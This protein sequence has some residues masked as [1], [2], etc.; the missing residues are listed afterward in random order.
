M[1]SLSFHL[2]KPS[3]PWS[4]QFLSSIHHTST[5][6]QISGSIDTFVL[7]VEGMIC[8]WVS[9]R[10]VSNQRSVEIESVCFGFRHA[11]K[12][13]VLASLWN[14]YNGLCLCVPSAL[15]ISTPYGDM[16][17]SECYMCA[18]ITL[19][20]TQSVPYRGS[21]ETRVTSHPRL[22]YKRLSYQLQVWN[23]KDWS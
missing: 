1:I 15:E 6:P 23:S 21:T 3:K 7:I 10:V 5:I 13:I 12:Q 18:Y 22:K 2:P 14:L 17:S 11:N 8:S 19:S 16:F 9:C 4:L 20:S